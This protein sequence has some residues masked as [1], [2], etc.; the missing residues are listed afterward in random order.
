[1][2]HRRIVCCSRVR[3]AIA[4]IRIFLFTLTDVPE[5]S[6]HPR[7]RLSMLAVLCVVAKRRVLKSE[8]FLEISVQLVETLVQEGELQVREVDLF[9]GVQAWVDHNPQERRGHINKVCSL[10]RLLTMAPRG[11]MNFYTL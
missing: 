3:P 8:G 2:L 9:A 5:P 11:T 6:N 10:L 1:M 4:C 7:P